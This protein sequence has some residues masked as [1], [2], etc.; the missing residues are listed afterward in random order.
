MALV[1]VM[2]KTTAQ[3]VASDKLRPVGIGGGEYIVSVN[4][5]SDVTHSDVHGT[6]NILEQRNYEWPEE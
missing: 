4:V 5:L 2:N 6:L 3:Q 1:I